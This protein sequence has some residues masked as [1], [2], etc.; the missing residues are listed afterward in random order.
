MSDDQPEFVVPHG[1]R[2]GAYA[3]A[4]KVWH[5]CHEFTL[6]FAV[7][8][9]WD[10]VGRTRAVVARVRL[11]TSGFFRVICGMNDA[12][13]AYESRWGSI[14]VPGAGEEP[15]LFP[16]DDLEGGTDV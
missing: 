4:V 10:D 15:P 5:S 12:L 16:P 2:S 9:H 1:L 6:D 8:S 14:V 7:E 13:D 3:N 11:P